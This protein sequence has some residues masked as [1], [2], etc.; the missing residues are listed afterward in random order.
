[1]SS[2][3]WRGLTHDE[4]RNVSL[5]I[6][7]EISFPMWGNWDNPYVD[8]HIT[9]R[10]HSN[11]FSA[12]SRTDIIIYQTGTPTKKFSSLIIDAG[13]YMKLKSLKCKMA[14]THKRSLP[15]LCYRSIWRIYTCQRL[16]SKR[17]RHCVFDAYER[18]LRRTEIIILYIDR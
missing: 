2:P 3:V 17:L 1:M 8:S 15:F 5:V 4:R 14:E 16:K 6:S 18:S 7:V 11:D 13:N 10:L 9:I 12:M